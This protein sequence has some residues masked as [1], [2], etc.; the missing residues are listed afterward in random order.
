MNSTGYSLSLF[1]T[2]Q[3]LYFFAFLGNLAII[4]HFITSN[5]LYVG[6][7][8]ASFTWLEALEFD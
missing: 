1:N 7:I 4:I 2:L 6:A 8:M 3:L 5:A